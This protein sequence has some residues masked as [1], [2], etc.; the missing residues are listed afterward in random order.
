MIRKGIE[1]SLEVA[2]EHH[3]IKDASKRKV[4]MSLNTFTPY[5]NSM[6]CGILCKILAEQRNNILNKLIIRKF[7]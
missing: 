2:S 1:R 4:E 3:S 7:I 6:T 5:I